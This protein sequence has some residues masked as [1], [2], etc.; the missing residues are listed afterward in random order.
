LSQTGANIIS[1]DHNREAQKSEINSCVVSMVLETRNTEHVNE[2]HSALRD[3]GYQI[4]N[5]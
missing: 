1:I 5:D 4:L 3:A 2:I